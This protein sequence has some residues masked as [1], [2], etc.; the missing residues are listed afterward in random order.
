MRW[1]ALC[2]YSKHVT[3]LGRFSEKCDAI[4]HSVTVIR[5]IGSCFAPRMCKSIVERSIFLLMRYWP[6]L[7]TIEWQIETTTQISCIAIRFS[8]FSKANVNA[9]HL[10]GGQKVNNGLTFVADFFISCTHLLGN[11]FI[12]SL[13]G[14]FLFL[15]YGLFDW[16][17]G[18]AT[19]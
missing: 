9:I 7:C 3:F 12:F 5:R 8:V 18:L 2:S 1:C 16:A 15:F 4:P 13:T 10:P 19:W 14:P 11:D 6:S 17:L